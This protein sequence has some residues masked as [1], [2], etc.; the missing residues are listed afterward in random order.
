MS[1]RPL[2]VTVIA[3][4][5]LAAGAL[6]LAYHMRE[7]EPQHPFQNGAVWVSLVRALAIICGV[8]MLRGNNWARWLALAWIAGHV[9]LSAFHSWGEFGMHGLIFIAIAYFLLRPQANRY[10][11]PAEAQAI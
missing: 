1:R 3:C 4:V 6:G 9:V 5:Y 8:Y 2:S 10:F 11:R 7:F